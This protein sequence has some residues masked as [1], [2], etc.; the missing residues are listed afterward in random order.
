M[1]EKQSDHRISLENKVVS[2]NIL[3]S[4]FGMLLAGIIAV[5]GLYVSKE[6]AIKGNPATAAI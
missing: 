2:S 4:Y 1:A 6:I 3:K 5:F